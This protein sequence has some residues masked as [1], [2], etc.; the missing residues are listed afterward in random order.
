LKYLENQYCA[1]HRRVPV[2]KPHNLPS[3]N[4]FFSATA[5]QSCQ[6]SLDPY[7]LSNDD[8]EYLTPNNVAETTPGRSDCAAPI[9]TAT[10]LYLNSPSE[11]PK[12]WWQINPNL[13]DYHLD[14]MECSS[15]FWIPDITDWWRQHQETRC[16]Y[17]DLSNV[18]RDIFSIIP[19]GVRVEARFSLGRDD[20]S[21]RQST[22]TGKTLHEKAV[23]RQF[24]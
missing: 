15:T 5:S 19:H 2:N 3:S 12:N 24:A 7:D 20:T 11:A 16:K 1:K 21:W 9:L 8:E 14:P 10:R 23:V 13:N 17:A 6:S 18:A 4:H 22:T